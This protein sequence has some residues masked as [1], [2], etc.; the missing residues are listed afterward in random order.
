MIN[1]LEIYFLN[2]AV[3]PMKYEHILLRLGLWA[4]Y[5]PILFRV[6]SLAL[7]QSYDCPTYFSGLLHWRWGNHMI[8]PV[9]VKQPWK[10]WVN[11]WHESPKNSWYNHNKTKH[12]TTMWIF[13]EIYCD[14]P[15]R[16]SLDS[17]GWALPHLG[18]YAIHWFCPFIW[19]VLI[20]Q[21]A[22]QIVD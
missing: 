15:C 18:S 1:C 19:S 5:L 22:V 6:A 12:N 7:G 3:F 9:P 16:N 21:M 10:I 20:K 8:A 13:Y 11:G 14:C 4:I 17:Y 2:T